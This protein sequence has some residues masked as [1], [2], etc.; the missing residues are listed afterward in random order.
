MIK[1]YYDNLDKY[2]KQG[3]A[4]IILGPR[5]VGKTTLLQN[6]LDKSKLKY[7]LDSGDNIRTQQI[8][9]SED[10]KQILE[11][12]KGY[13]LL[14]IDEAQRIPGI[15]QGLKILVDQLP[16]LRIIATGS[17]SFDLANQV[18]EPL[19]GRKT[20]LKLFPIAETELSDSKNTFELKEELTELM[21]FGSYPEVLL[22]KS[23]AEKINILEETTNSYLFKDILAFD[24]I[25][26]PKMLFDL[27][28][29]LAFQIGKEVSLN[30]LSNQL[31]IDVKTVARYLDLLEKSFVI[32]RLNGYSGN[33][34]SEVTSKSKYFFLDN[35]IRN[36]VISQFNSLNDRNDVGQLWEN[37]VIA[38]RL[39][40][41]TYL[42]IYGNSYFWRTYGGQEIDLV[43][44]RDGRLFGF[45]CKW[46]PLKKVLPPSD[47]SAYKNA[48]FKIINREN[49][50][51]FIS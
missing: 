45:E 30:E 15:G 18:G 5:R 10:F 11:Y 51:D 22:A 8:L 50:L 47:W 28:K 23:K 26:N 6:Y 4:L 31:S 43:E 14:A 2:L 13:E 27:L 42:G 25:K 1:R 36:A 34:R 16:G 24:K 48:T 19:T 9:G 38:E 12:I 35:G 7:K 32:F 44:E 39:K 29:L 41:R 21:I 33:L 37:F 40:K 17:S 20:T 49:Y 3:K 46:S